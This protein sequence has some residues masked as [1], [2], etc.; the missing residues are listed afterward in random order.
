MN[1]PRAFNTAGL[2]VATVLI[3]VLC[4][5]GYMA[6]TFVTEAMAAAN[7]Y[8]A[9]EDKSKATPVSYSSNVG[10]ENDIKVRYGKML[11]VF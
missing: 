5:F 2:P 6:A 3:A 9:M 10:E 1:L 8:A 4:L 7:A 11:S